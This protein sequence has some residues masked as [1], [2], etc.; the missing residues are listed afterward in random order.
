MLRK[1]K[2]MTFLIA[3]GPSF[4]NVSHWEKEYQGLEMEPNEFYKSLVKLEL[5]KKRALDSKT[6]TS[7]KDQFNP[8][9]YIARALGSANAV[10]KFTSDCWF[11]CDRNLFT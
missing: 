1:I 10:C 4:E 8:A 2:Q 3:H 5:H 9:T 7:W 11:P 6:S